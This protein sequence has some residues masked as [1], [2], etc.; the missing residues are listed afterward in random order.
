M[1]ENA[2]A[3]PIMTLLLVAAI[4]L[5]IPVFRYAI[6][7][8]YL[9]FVPGFVILKTFKLK[10]L[11]LLNTLLISVGL[12]L[13]ASMSI[14]L[15]VNELYTILKLSQPLSVIPLTTAMSTFTLILF[16]ISYRRDSSINFIFL[17]G[18]LKAT[19]TY[20]PLILLL[21]I[22][23]MLSIVSA[24][25]MHIPV[26]I[27]FC[28][29]IA[30]LCVLSVVSDKLIPSEAYPFLIFSISISIL[31]LN[32]LSSKQVM[33]FDANLEYY[34]FKDNQIRG[35]WGPI[36]IFSQT[37]ASLTY[38]A[39]LSI[40]LLPNVYSSLMNLQND[41]LLFKILYS[42][43]FSLLPITLYGVYRAETGKLVGLLSTLFFVFSINAF[44][45]E[46]IGVNRQIVAEFFFMLFILIWLNETFPIKEKRILLVI[47]GIS[48]ALS[49]YSLAVIFVILVSLIVIV[50]SI[51][52]KFDDV[53]NAPTLLTIFGATFLWYAFSLGS[54]LI[55]IVNT[56]Q[57][58]F[59]ELLNSQA[60]AAGTVST[61]YG[62][63]TVFTAASWINLAV[64]GLVNLLLL[65]GILFVIFL[66]RRIGAS[67]SSRYRFLTFFAAIM[68]AASFAFPAVAGTLNFTR[69]FAISLLFLSP[70]VTIGGLVLLN[71]IQSA[72]GKRK[73]TR[74]NIAFLNKRTKKALLL[75][76]ILFGAYFLSQ[77]G[78]INY[79]TGGAIHNIRFD[80]YRLKTSSDP[81]DQITFYFAYTPHQDVS[82]AIWLSKYPNASSVVYADV[83]SG[84][85]VLYSEGL[86]PQNLILPLTNTTR[87][88]RNSFVYLGSVNVAKGIIPTSDSGYFNTSEI[89]SSLAESDLVYSNGDSLIWS[90]VGLG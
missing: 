90:V 68:F 75:V 18:M 55:L 29:A 76:A 65:V 56:I 7:F 88:G 74:N 72:L 36:N 54:I 16:F 26:M 87:P 42:F 37:S 86:I 10:G 51:K 82:S 66:P 48:I 15:L 23:S 4:L 32:L 12:S 34:V 41:V 40:T 35:Y 67:F 8:T 52:S 44:F 17:D 83:I 5:N 50:S 80:Y 53:F 78:F 59:S 63:P 45:G 69:F 1:R 64:S 20:L 27:I 79:V 3:I 84:Q 33:G 57:T 21:I 70:C 19:R 14:G 47:F 81:Q 30:V 43:I 28:L 61:V 31:L 60:R 9:S 73:E 62:L 38:N 2:L 58:V 49:H 24:L 25:Y 71:T 6:V 46:L 89:S 22:I 85:Q 11:G 39:M 77:S 13:V